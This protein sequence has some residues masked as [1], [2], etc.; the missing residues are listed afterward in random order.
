MYTDLRLYMSNI[1]H[2]I[3]VSREGV[4]AGKPINTWIETV[5]AT[6]LPLAISCAGAGDAT[7]EDGTKPVAY[8]LLGGFGFPG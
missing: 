4:D 5:A 6:G 7:P 3:G 1:L 8:A 2:N